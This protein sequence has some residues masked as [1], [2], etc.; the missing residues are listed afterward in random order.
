MTAITP[1]KMRAIADDLKS[2]AAIEFGAT[3]DTMFAAQTALRAAADQLET[4]RNLTFA[5][6]MMM[7]PIT[8]RPVDVIFVSD[9]PDG[10]IADF[11][12]L[13]NP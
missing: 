4:V 10:L 13:E 3:G 8:N 7:H 1:E 6:P 12:P 9:L 2:A 11:T 5:S